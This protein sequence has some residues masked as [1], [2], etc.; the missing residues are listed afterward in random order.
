MGRDR[1][2]GAGVGRYGDTGRGLL[3]HRR[4]YT[5][6]GA[7]GEPGTSAID[8]KEGGRADGGDDETENIAA[9]AAAESLQPGPAVVAAADEEA[10]HFE[11]RRRGS[12]RRTYRG[13]PII[14]DNLAAD[15]EA[16]PLPKRRCR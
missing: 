3:R 7:A 12:H 13:A 16:L 5:H 14:T 2:C 10:C 11:H 6:R 1:G 15:E 8:L 4:R 9:R